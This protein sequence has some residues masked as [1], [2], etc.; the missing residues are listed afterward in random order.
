[1]LESCEEDRRQILQVR[2]RD[3]GGFGGDDST[4]RR[5]PLEKVGVG[6]SLPVLEGRVAQRTKDL[7][8]AV[9]D[10]AFAV[11]KRASVDGRFS[12][13]RSPCRR[14]GRSR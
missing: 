5:R 3:V 7:F 8:S 4:V 14:I 2:C 10:P 9:K 12:D 11:A 6:E 1:M 13:R